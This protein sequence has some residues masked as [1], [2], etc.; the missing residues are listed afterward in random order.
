MAFYFDFLFRYNKRER[1]CPLA[2]FCLKKPFNK[3]KT[4]PIRR[5]GE[6]MLTKNKDW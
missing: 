3:L 2:L 6:E 1:V 4:V 5:H